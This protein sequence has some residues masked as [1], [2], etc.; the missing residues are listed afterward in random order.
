MSAVVDQLLSEPEIYFYLNPEGKLAARIPALLEALNPAEVAELKTYVEALTL[1][2]RK[3]ARTSAVVRPPNGQNPGGTEPSPARIDVH[4]SPEMRS[5]T[6][7]P[8]PEP[9]HDR[10]S[11][12]GPGTHQHPDIWEVVVEPRAGGGP[13]QIVT[14]RTRDEVRER[15]RRQFG[16]IF[17]Y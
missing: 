13:H 2:L 6:P 11:T 7:D 5:D 17:G 10:R 9:P 16:S 1:I 4:S 8:A 3:E 12:P 15:S 14:R